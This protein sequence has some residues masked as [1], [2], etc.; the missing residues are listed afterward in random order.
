MAFHAMQSSV[1]PYQVRCF[2]R[3]C[4]QSYWKKMELL[5]YVASVIRKILSMPEKYRQIID[6][7]IENKRG[8]NPWD[9]VSETHK[10]GGAWDSVYR[11]GYGNRS[12]ISIRQIRE[13]G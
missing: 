11:G 4:V 8:L 5:E 7:I 3:I 9:M 6:R 2:L 13:L 1:C 12:T 10:M